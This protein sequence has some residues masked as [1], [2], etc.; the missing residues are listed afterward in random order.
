MT[1]AV[2]G[3]PTLSVIRV[4]CASQERM[5]LVKCG[6]GWAWKHGS[7]RTSVIQFTSDLTLS[8]QLQDFV[9]GVKN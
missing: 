7:V 6:E 4:A 2:E 1:W 8:F 3:N 5:M 9:H